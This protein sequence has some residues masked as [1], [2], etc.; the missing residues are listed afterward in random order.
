MVKNT[1]SFNLSLSL[2]VSILPLE[3]TPLNSFLYSFQKMFTACPYYITINIIFPHPLVF[4]KLGQS[5]S[6]LPLSW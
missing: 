2:Q 3:V 1:L 4:R 5:I 6:L